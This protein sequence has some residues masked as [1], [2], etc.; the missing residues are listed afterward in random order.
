MIHSVKELVRPV[1]IEDQFCV[2]EHFD[3]RFAEKSE[4][5][6]ENNMLFT[7]SRKLN[8]NKEQILTYAIDEPINVLDKAILIV[9]KSA[10]E[11]TDHSP[12]T[13]NK[14]HFHSLSLFSPFLG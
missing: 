9:M 8:I 12:R 11:R 14:K 4:I 1:L 2:C 3:N 5:V 6:Q 7:N 10:E 13:L